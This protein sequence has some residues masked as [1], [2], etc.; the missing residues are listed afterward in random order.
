MAFLCSRKALGSP[1]E[2]RWSPES[3]C[4]IA[5]R[6]RESFSPSHL[7]SFAVSAVMGR[8]ITSEGNC[9]PCLTLVSLLRFGF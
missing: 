3:P 2:R 7:G 9:S 8:G 6:G 4:R 5:E 1:G